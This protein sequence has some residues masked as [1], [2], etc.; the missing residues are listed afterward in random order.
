MKLKK[1]NVLFSDGERGVGFLFG[2]FANGNVLVF[3]PHIYENAL[4]DPSKITD[5]ISV[6]VRR[7]HNLYKP[8]DGYTFYLRG[9]EDNFIEQALVTFSLFIGGADNGEVISGAQVQRALAEA[10]SLMGIYR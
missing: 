7:G 3:T 1:V 4:D 5:S 6:M 10:R 8:L 2:K 9:K